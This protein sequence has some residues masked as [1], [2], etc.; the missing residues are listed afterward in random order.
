VAA[1]GEEMIE[2]DFP[3]DACEIP[4]EMQVH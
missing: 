1:G 2:E 3:D 4:L